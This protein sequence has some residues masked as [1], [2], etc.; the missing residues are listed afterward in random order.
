MIRLPFILSSAMPNIKHGERNLARQR[1]TTSARVAEGF[2][3]YFD[4]NIDS[5][6]FSAATY[7]D[8][9]EFKNMSGRRVVVI[10]QSIIERICS[11]ESDPP[12]NDSL[13]ST[14]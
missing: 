3:T 2:R 5:T 11:G 6:M 14:H 9:K 4:Q 1:A 10:M 12:E 13:G 7:P 8:R